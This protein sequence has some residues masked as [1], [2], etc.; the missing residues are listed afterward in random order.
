LKRRLAA[1]DA[2]A[3]GPPGAVAAEPEAELQVEPLVVEGALRLAAHPQEEHVAPPRHRQLVRT[4]RPAGP[5]HHRPELPRPVLLVVALR[6]ALRL[7]AEPVERARP[8]P[9]EV[10]RVVEPHLLRPAL[11][12]STAASP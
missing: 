10:V 11:C 6:A 7:A 12:A 9:P 1:A 4:A 3:P 5:M 8:A 2:A